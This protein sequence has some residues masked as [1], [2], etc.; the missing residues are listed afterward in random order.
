MAIREVRVLP[1]GRV[2]AILVSHYPAAGQM[3]KVLIFAK[4]DDRW[5]IDAVIEAPA[6]TGILSAPVPA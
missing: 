4:G 2:S 1:D 6:A 3:R 5:R